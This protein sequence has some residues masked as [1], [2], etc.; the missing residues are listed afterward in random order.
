M[1]KNIKK[2]N[3]SINKKVFVPTGTSQVLIKAA[4]KV[5][6]H[7]KKNLDLG[8]GSGIVGITLAQTLKSKIK[9]IFF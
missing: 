6:K 5:I 4:K 9:N 8:C 1:S 2:L 7:K 3:F